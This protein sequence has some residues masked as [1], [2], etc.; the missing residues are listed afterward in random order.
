MNTSRS[1]RMYVNMVKKDKKL[2]KA[3]LSNQ[4]TVP[5]FRFSPEFVLGN[6][7]AENVLIAIISPYCPSCAALYWSIQ[8]Y[9]TSD[10]ELVKVILRFKPGER[11]DGWDNQ[12]IEYMY[13]FNMDNKKERAI[14]I[15]EEWYRMDYKEITV[16][17]KNCGLENMIVSDEA[18]QIRSEYHK[19][20]LSFDLQGAP[21]MILNN[22]LIPR[23][24]SFDDVKYFLK[25][26]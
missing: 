6:K 12:I 25:R 23:H 24:Y 26:I 21:E 13:T 1:M 10:A 9:L 5:E 11:D 3:I 15:L 22:K 14:S 18:R 19:W 2:F 20:L 17:K 16:W 4:D 8:R 7:E